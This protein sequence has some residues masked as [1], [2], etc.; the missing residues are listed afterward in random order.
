M[1]TEAQKKQYEQVVKDMA[2]RDIEIASAAGKKVAQ[3]VEEP[4]RKVLLSGDII[5]G[6]FTPD[7]SYENKSHVV[8]ML[9]LLV[10]NQERDFY[11]Y[12]LPK[13]GTLPERRVESDYLMVPT[14]RIGN[15]IDAEHTFIEDANWNVISRMM[16]ILE[17][18]LVK[19]INDDGWQ[20]IISAATDRNV[21]IYDQ[22]ASAGQFTPTLVTLM[23]TF[24]RRNGGGNSATMNRSKL[25]DLYVSPEAM[26]DIRSWNLELVA[27]NVRANIYYSPDDG[28]EIVRIFGVN[29]HDLDELGEGQEYQ[30]YFSTSLGGSMQGTDTEIVVGLDLS[31]KESVFVQPIK[32]ALRMFEDN[33][34][35]RQGLFG[36]YANLQMGLSC[37]DSRATLLGSI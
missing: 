9:D 26:D 20:T 2:S 19:K 17:A 6:I 35:H 7:T 14:Y 22:N 11:A 13:H 15:A 27:D 28:N 1:Y 33:T 25:T 30:N 36:I 21:M 29:I 16:E 34:K 32:K 10:P 18:G 12:V 5:S 23:K 4:I 8:Y 3:A 24:M 37:L 31:R